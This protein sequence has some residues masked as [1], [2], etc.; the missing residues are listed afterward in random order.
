MNK[1]NNHIERDKYE[2][3]SLIF[4]I[5]K[6]SSKSKKSKTLNLH[7]FLILIKILIL[8]NNYLFLCNR[9][10]NS[11]NKNNNSNKTMKHA[12]LLLSSYGISYMNNVLSQFSND[13]RFD[14]Y[15]HIDGKTKIDIENNKT[16]T[17]A[18][19]K[20]I[21]HLFSSKRFSTKM[22]DAMLELLIIAYKKDNYDYF[23]YFSDSCY[24]IE[25]LDDFYQFFIKNNNQSYIKYHLE[26]YFLYK[27]K[28]FKL[29]KGSQWMSLHNNIVKKLLDNINIFHKYKEALKNK[30]IKLV[31]G[32]PDEFI[33]QHIIVND[34]CKRKPQ[35]Y[36]I[37]NNNLRFI[38]WRSCWKEYCPNYLI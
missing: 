19:I 6:V 11:N 21:K 27:G 16:I 25:T 31:K 9:G 17:R 2:N 38:R 5:K 32:A 3:V 34:I 29:Y 33:I 8:I 28:S 7:F 22:V 26:K 37:I 1:K 35:E 10:N 36:N 23:H 24:L 20:Y 18:K 14:I 30:M 12:I 13:E 4:Q 15:I